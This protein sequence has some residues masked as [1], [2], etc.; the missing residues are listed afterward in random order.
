LP[1]TD[2]ML[3]AVVFPFHIPD[4][5]LF[6]HLELV[7]PDLKALFSSA[8][9]SVSP[10]MIQALP[11]QVARLEEDDFFKL[12]PVPSDRPVGIQFHRLYEQAAWACPPTQVLHLCFADRLAYILES[13]HRSA[14]QRD[15][16]A[17]ASRQGSL[18]FQRSKAAWETHPT[19]YA[20][21]E[22]LATTA[23]EYIL[24]QRLDFTWCHLA[25]SAARL[26]EIMPQVQ[27]PDLSM[28]AEMILLLRH[29][30]RTQEVDW[31]AWEDP[32]LLSQ[33][34]QRLKTVREQSPAET[35]TRLAS[36]IPILQTPA[37]AIPGDSPGA[38]TRAGEAAEVVKRFNDALNAHDPD[39]MMALMTPGCIFENTSPAPDESRL[40]GQSAVRAFWVDFFHHA[41]HAQ[42]EIEELFSTGS[43]VVMRWRYQWRQTAGEIGHVR[44]VDV[45]SI[46]DG[47]IAEKFSYV[48]G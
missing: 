27:H 14:F 24:G 34:A 44:G 15:I 40:E 29:D 8:L 43:R 13:E 39:G 5:I 4:E 18:L 45:Y 31:L 6:A 23:G 22:G 48:K 28:L 25:L 46:R 17:A 20:A 35:S 38:Q 42:I 1:K 2:P 21:I 12:L 36:V 33:P 32:H 37:E 9:L 7:L 19:N 26:R 3:P 47:L 11:R 16:L 10:A 41:P 30:L